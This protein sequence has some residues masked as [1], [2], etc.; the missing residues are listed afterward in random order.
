MTLTGNTQLTV[1]K[2]FSTLMKYFT[3]PYRRA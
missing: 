2:K 3:L 1:F